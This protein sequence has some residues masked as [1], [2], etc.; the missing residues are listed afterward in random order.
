MKLSI[1]ISPVSVADTITQ[2]TAA[3][4]A[5]IEGVWLTNIFG[6][7]A[8][9]AIAAA[10]REVPGMR[11]GTAVVP[12]SPRHP[13]A[14]AQQAMT[15]WDATNGQFSLGIGASHQF[16]IESM[17]GLTFARPAAQ[18]REYLDVLRPLL[19]SGAVASDGRTYR[20]HAH[21]ERAGPSS[22]PPVLVAALGPA[23][24]R[25]A[26]EIADGT[27]LWM[28]GPATI[29]SHIAPSIR[30]AAQGAGRPEPAIVCSLPVA[31]TNDPDSLRAIAATSFAV[32]EDLPSYRAM[33]DREGASVAGDLA[34]IGDESHVATALERL[35]AA[36]VTEFSAHCFGAPDDIRRTIQL[37]HNLIT[38]SNRSATANQAGA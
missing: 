32:Y 22:G 14:L 37:L 6:L 34:I 27:V 19:H 10:S 28:T 36:G 38:D 33:L 13:Y 21:L 5:G 9:T 3:H 4:A 12:A 8:I 26:G 16:I 30:A 18:M 20:V 23:M 29:E 31:V 7:D 1:T 24:L 17:L 15:A 2:A 11:F 35:S 25:V